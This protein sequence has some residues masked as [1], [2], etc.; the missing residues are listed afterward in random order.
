HLPQGG[1]FTAFNNGWYTW[2]ASDRA[3]NETVQYIE[4]G[5]IDRASPTLSL[6]SSP[7]GWAVGSVQITASTA[8]DLSGIKLT[9]WAAGSQ[10]LAFFKNGAGTMFSDSFTVTDNGGYTVYAEDQAGNAVT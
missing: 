2:Y 1:T 6:T 10:P 9:K 7:P 8:D 4:I 3:G 5:N